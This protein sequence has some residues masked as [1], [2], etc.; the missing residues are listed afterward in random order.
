MSPDQVPDDASERCDATC[1][2]LTL[3][4][5]VKWYLLKYLLSCLHLA[6]MELMRRTT[7]NRVR[8]GVLAETLDLIGRPIDLIE[9]AFVWLV[10]SCSQWVQ[11][12][13]AKYGHNRTDCDL[14]F[15]PH[16]GLTKLKILSMSVNRD[17]AAF[18]CRGEN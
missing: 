10:S 11:G 17:D 8:N 13:R 9:S 2:S 18:A 16:V 6:R 5:W 12:C 1:A 15:L 4:V 7:S 3:G 14:C